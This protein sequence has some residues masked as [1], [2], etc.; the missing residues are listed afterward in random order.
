VQHD[1]PVGLH[2][3][4]VVDGV[5]RDGGEVDRLD[6]ERA[7]LVHAGEQEQVLDEQAH[8]AALAL[9]PLH[10]P[11]D[12]VVTA[13]G[14]LPVQLGEA[15]DRGERG[16]QLVA[17][18]GDEPPHP[19]LRATRLGLGRLLGAEGALDPG[20]HPVQRGG[21]SA[22][23][24]AVVALGHPLGQV[25]VGDPASGAL[26]L[27]ERTEAVAHQDVPGGAQH[28]QHDQ[29]DDALDGHESADGPLIA[30]HVGAD[31]DRPAARPLDGD[32]P[33]GGVPVVGVHGD[34]WA[35]G[36]QVVDEF[37]VVR[38]VTVVPR[39]A[40]E[41][42]HR[43]V[44]RLDA[45]VVVGAAGLAVAGAGARV[46]QTRVALH[47]LRRGA[48]LGVLLALQ[49]ATQECLRRESGGQ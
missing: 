38:K 29:P 32:H 45:G 30:L 39:R 34:R 3:A 18:V 11:P 20:E 22:D 46:E 19:V 6:R 41:D 40:E 43:I 12:V 15:A 16:A 7:L 35:A 21:Q 23:L 5:A 36:D 17:G 8:P 47:L 42:G 25:A 14:A 4:G 13:H 26:H 27:G 24:G 2:G 48:Q 44:A 10:Q 31:H 1:R 28:G 9:D 37:V 49:V 33:P